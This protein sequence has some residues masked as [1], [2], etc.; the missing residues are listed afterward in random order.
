[1]LVIDSFKPFAVLVES[2]S[3]HRRFLH[4]LA[5]RLSIRALT[6]LWLGEYA[7]SD[8]ATA[9]EFAVA[10]S[11]LWL[12]A[13]RHEEREI[14][15]LQVLKLRGSDF[16]SGKHAYRLSV[17]GMRVFPRLADPGD[18][19]GYELDQ[20][21]ISSGVE[22]LDRVLGEG[23]PAGSSTLVVGPSGVGKTVLGLHFAFEGARQGE[24]TLFATFDE[25]PSQLARAAASFGWSLDA[26]GLAL[27]YRSAVDLYL[28]EWVYDLLDLI[29]SR[30]IRRVV[31]DGLSNLRV[32]A[33]EPVRFHEY[34]Y[35]LVQRCARK[36]V[37]V[38][39]SL[40]SGELFGMSRLGE[41][42]LSQV[43]DN[44]ILLQFVRRGGEYR[45]GLTVLKSR[46]ARIEPRLSEYTIGSSGIELRRPG[47][48]KRA[49]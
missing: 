19:S 22:S 32:A 23:Y 1:L 14:R 20:G 48:A 26:P 45:R 25:N 11:V 8:M 41:V 9:P 49:R 46:S 44:V 6:S 7:V 38:M 30:G 17:E 35:S 40:E 47:D 24:G 10:D 4:E 29:E 2:P 5:A 13:G 16:R 21:R 37:N 28:D 15:M 12:T 3:E 42:S 36:R 18:E 39:M 43:A 33:Q 27:L 31:I 34:V